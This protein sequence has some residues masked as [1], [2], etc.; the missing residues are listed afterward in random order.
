MADEDFMFATSFFQGF[1][2]RTQL[3]LSHGLLACLAVGTGVAGVISL[4]QL[5]SDYLGYVEGSAKRLALANE[6]L[7]ATNAR[8]IAARNLVLVS[9]A[10]DIAAEK[11]AV[12]QSGKALESALAQLEARL[13]SNADVSQEERD[14]FK[15]F[16]EVESR[17]GP[18]ATAIVNNAITGNKD[19]ATVSMIE[20]CRP[21]LAELLTAGHAYLDLVTKEAAAQA[22]AQAQASTVSK[23]VMMALVLLSAFLSV[24]LTWLLVRSIVGSLGAEPSQLA[25]FAKTVAAG[26]LSDKKDSQPGGYPANSV[27]ASLVEMQASLSRIVRDV[28]EASSS[29]ANGSSEIALGNSDLSQRTEQQASS[30]QE[31]AASMEQLNGT[32]QTNASTARHAVEVS[33]AASHSAEQGGRIVAEVI[34]TMEGISQT[35]S[36]I[37]DII[38][39]IDGIAFQTNILALNAAVEA[40]RAGEQGRGF[41]VVAAEVRTLAQRSANAAREIKD[42]IGGSVERVEAGSQLV[43]KAGV[44]MGEIVNQVKQVTIMIGEISSATDDQSTGIGQVSSAVAQLDNATQ[45]NAA[46][47]EQSAAASASLKQQSEKLAELVSVFKI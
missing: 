34:E 1:R 23:T 15:A 40:A 18:V 17:Y 7:E 33:S 32:V 10:E 38:G 36:K 27:M 29:I 14:S 12:D 26:D 44:S 42:L 8:A 47:V 28:R 21:L 22:Q 41:A 35:S 2:T 25:T 30:L 11:E 37:A 20:E 6:V 13:A 46:L 9:A 43:G 16:Q 19:L 4:T 3:L 31:T 39:V 5:Q 24:T 45:Q